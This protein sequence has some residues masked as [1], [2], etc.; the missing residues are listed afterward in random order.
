MHKLLGVIFAV[1]SATAVLAVPA[2]ASPAGSPIAPLGM[3]VSANNARS[4]VDIVNSGATIYEGDQ[5]G[6]QE[7]GSMLVRI[8][9]GKLFLHKA[10]SVQ[11]HA[12]ANG[13]SAD[14]GSGVVS[15]SSDEG[16]TFQLLTNGLTIRPATAHPTAAQIER[17][18]AT[19]VVV[20]STRGDLQVSMGDEVETVTA[21]NSY[22]VEMGSPASD[23]AYP[24]AYPG[25]G[26][27]PIAGRRSKGFYIIVFSAVAAATAILIWR[28]TESPDKPH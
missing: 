20:I 12:L 10:T 21:G 25:Q 28:A 26:P 4:G 11:M 23:A 5:L 1:A 2:P 7:D 18:S 9:T 8:G 17:V 19:E 14:L 3:V 24:G 27:P 16:R 13:F 22:K 6:T 15:V